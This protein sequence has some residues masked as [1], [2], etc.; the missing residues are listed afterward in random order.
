M[1]QTT[2]PSFRERHGYALA[3]TDAHRV[4]DEEVVSLEDDED[5]VLEHAAPPQLNGELP[6]QLHQLLDPA[7]SSSSALTEESDKLSSAA[8]VPATSPSASSL[9]PYHRAE[10]STSASSFTS[11]S[12][13]GDSDEDVEHAVDSTTGRIRRF[14][15]RPSITINSENGLQH[16]TIL[17]ESSPLTPITPVITA[18]LAAAPRPTFWQRWLGFTLLA[19]SAFFFSLMS[20]FV[21]LTDGRVNSFLLIWWR[22]AT[23]FSVAVLIL[24]A[25][26]KTMEEIMGERGKRKWIVARAVV[27]ICSLSC[28]YYSLTTLPL[29]EAT[30]L[31]FTAPVY[32]GILGRVMLKESFDRYDALASALSFL[33][34]IFVARPAVFFGSSADDDTDA[35]TGSGTRTFSV[36]VALLGAF[37]GALVYIY[38]RKVGKGTNPLVLVHVLGLIGFVLAPIDALF[39]TWTMPQG[40]DLVYMCFVGVFAFCGQVLFNAGVQKEKA[41]FSSLMRNVSRHRL[42]SHHLRVHSRVQFRLLTARSLARSVC[43][44]W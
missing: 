22:C 44:C 34:V 9:I 18:A 37:M 2:R 10:R 17:V 4:H 29:S 23:Q 26:R 27:G 8:A 14:I 42:E 21:S 40:V 3:S 19:V 20:L 12:S 7:S 41:G 36:F 16:Q 1:E 30:T 28:F 5:E 15:R 13:Q 33:G 24:V 6:D 31:F 32:C 43:V 39:E 25:Q 38:I 35:S 11:S